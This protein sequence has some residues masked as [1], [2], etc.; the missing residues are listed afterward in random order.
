MERDFLEVVKYIMTA[1]KA[2]IVGALIFFAVLIFSGSLLRATTLAFICV[3]LSCFATWRRYLEPLSFA[4]FIAAA[5]FWCQPD[6]L[7]SAKV[8]ICGS[9]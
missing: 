9:T 4:A 8:A 1:M 5:I 6:V 7:A 3:V 2:F